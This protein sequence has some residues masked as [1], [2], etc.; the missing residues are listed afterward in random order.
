MKA[1]LGYIVSLKTAWTSNMSV[2]IKITKEQS[3]VEIKTPQDD[4]K[5]LPLPRF[6]ATQASVTAISEWIQWEG[7]LCGKD[8]TG[9]WSSAWLQLDLWRRQITWAIGDCYHR[10]LF[11][12][13][14]IL[15]KGKQYRRSYTWK[16]LGFNSECLSSM[17]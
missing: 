3:R 1:S 7:N 4:L 13:N 2:C 6:R 11:R 16:D 15:P 14:Q 8:H 9:M 17:L 10:L 5:R 12:N